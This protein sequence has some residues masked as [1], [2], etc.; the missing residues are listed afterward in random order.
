[1]APTILHA[2]GKEVRAK[3]WEAYVLLT[4]HQRVSQN[5]QTNIFPSFQ[6]SKGY[7]RKPILSSGKKVITATQQQ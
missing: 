4:Q 3:R 2:T 7:E 1:M 6:I 5:N